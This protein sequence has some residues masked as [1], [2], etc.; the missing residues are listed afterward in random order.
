MMQHDAVHIGY[1]ADLLDTDGK[2]SVECTSVRYRW[3]KDPSNRTS[4]HRSIG[5]CKAG[6]DIAKNGFHKGGPNSN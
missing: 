1:E 3:E 6:K 5:Q 2:R 4:R